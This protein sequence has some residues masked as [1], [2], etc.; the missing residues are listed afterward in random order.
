MDKTIGKTSAKLLKSLYNKNLTIFGIEDA[1]KILGY[2]YSSAAR[3][4]RKMVKRNLLARIKSGRYFIVPQEISGQYIGNWYV[5]AKAIVNSKEYYISHY[6]AMDIHNMLTQPLNKVYISSPKRQTSP[7]IFRER[8]KYVYI[9][10]SKIWGVEDY[11]VTNQD[12]VRV[13]NIERT[14]IDCLWQPKYAGGITEIA[15]GVWIVRDK[16]DFQALIDY[17][18]KFN[19]YVVNKRAGFIL[20]TLKLGSNILPTLRNNINRRYD[21]LDP[22]MPRIE[23]FK[24]NWNLI[25][26]L[27]PDEIKNIIRT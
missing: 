18:L 23:I 6:S 4:L 2:S 12:K 13:S 20:E 11:W 16:I 21:V 9:K 7:K 8:F 19:K 25:A 26:N 14:I 10:N 15:K 22:S 17:C 27:N 1:I 5:A 3:F 24:N